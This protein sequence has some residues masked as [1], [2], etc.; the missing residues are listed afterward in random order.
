MKKGAQQNAKHKPNTRHTLNEVL[1]SLQDMMHNELAGVDLP[2]DKNPAG[3]SNKEDVLKNLKTLI[4]SNTDTP[5]VDQNELEIPDD[6]SLF[7]E[8]IDLA[9]DLDQEMLSDS[10]IDFENEISS[11]AL[12]ET[13]LPPMDKIEID[14]DAVTSDSDV[15]DLT[16]DPTTESDAHLPLENESAE[17]DDIAEPTPVETEPPSADDFALEME[18][19]NIPPPPP[20]KQKENSAKNKPKNQSS[21]SEDSAT[22]STEQ[23]EINWDDIPVLDEVVAPP[24]TPDDATSKQAREI[25]IK[26][27]AALNIELR[28]QGTDAMDIKTIMRLQSLLGRELADHGGTV[29]DELDEPGSDDQKTND[30]DV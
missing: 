23:V 24:P 26:V 14:A 20:A 13:E 9:D 8:E 6:A 3:S 11:Q 7:E 21:A 10:S 30:D 22:S 29:D 2:P 12:D 17:Q 4:G 1:H 16:S 27:A 19:A 25:A 5:N 18:D 28:K 15:T